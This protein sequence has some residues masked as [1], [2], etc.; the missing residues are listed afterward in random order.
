MTKKKKKKHV[1]KIKNII[2]ILL[3]LLALVGLFYY[4]I[5]MPIKNVYIKGNTMVSDE[6]IMIIS[7]LDQY[8]SFLLTKKREL[9]NLIIKN[10]YINKVKITK[11]IGNIIEVNITEYQVIA[12]TTEDKIILSNGRK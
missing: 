10:E 1:L 9:Q 5:T 12:V 4:A 6:E 2:I 8:P 11:K 3:I 7:K